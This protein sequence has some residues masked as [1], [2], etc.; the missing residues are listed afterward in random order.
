MWGFVKK[1]GRAI[2]GAISQTANVVR[3]VANRTIGIPDFILTLFG[4][5][6][7]KRML[8]RAVILRNESTAL[9]SNEATVQDALYYANAI[10]KEKMNVKILPA[11][12]DA[13]QL[14]DYAAPTA[15]LEPRCG[16]V[17]TGAWADDMGV[18]G[19]Y[20][21]TYLA[22]HP[23]RSMTGYGAPITVFIVRS[24]RGDYKGCSLGP[25][26]DYVTVDLVGLG[27]IPDPDVSTPR[28]RT[29]AHEIGHAC[30]LP[31]AASG[32]NLMLPG[33]TGTDLGKWQKATFRNSRHVT[34]F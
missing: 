34:F 24:I 11:G 4:L 1:V 22:V 8:V 26:E 33:G 29:I 19:E 3:E 20:F 32:S 18:A 2:T 7:P 27:D 30:G 6:L 13:V 9:I 16:T 21:R 12:G 31:H 17:G 14:L 15:A 25:L 10:F 5:Y 23:I 28:S